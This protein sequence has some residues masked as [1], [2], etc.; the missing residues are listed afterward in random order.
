MSAFLLTVHS[1]A[2][3]PGGPEYDFVVEQAD[4]FA[5]GDGPYPSRWSTH[6]YTR[7][8]PGDQVYLLAQ[9]QPY[10]GIIA[11]GYLTTGESYLDESFRDST[12]LARYV[13]VEWD[14]FVSVDDALATSQL[15]EL[16]PST[17]WSPMS[18]GQQIDP[19]DETAV[20]E[21]WNEHLRRT[22][23]TTSAPIPGHAGPTE[24][25]A[26]Y[27]IA[28]TI[29][30]QHQAAFRRILLRHQAPECFYCGLEDVRLLEAAHIEPDAD[31]GES[32]VENGLLLCPNHHKAF[33]RGILTWE[34]GHLVPADGEDD[35]PP[36]LVDEEE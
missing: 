19:S 7:F 18:G 22:V 13:D 8:R 36:F 24:V 21:A 17:N 3:A 35:V 27:R 1:R 29:V 6:A 32:S 34:D 14:A 15:V 26:R 12:G 4:L 31:G 33:D 11:S 28:Q 2:L 30:R 5:S 23:S 20:L 10:R 9:G 25:M 16:A